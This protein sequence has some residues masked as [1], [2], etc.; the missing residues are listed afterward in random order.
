[1]GLKRALDGGCDSIEH[2]LDLDDAAIAQMVK[3]GTWYCPTMSPYY[4]DWEPEGTPA[5]IRDRKRAEVH[6]PSLQKAMKA[7]VKIA[8]G[9][10][11]GGFPWSD[12]M[13]QEFRRMVE[14][15]MTPAA[16]IRSATS[17]AAEMLGMEG[18]IGTIAPGAWAD[19]VAVTGDPLRDVRILEKID[20]VMKDGNVYRN[21]RR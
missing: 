7:G 17:S 3:Q 2:G 18:K 8:F 5:G 9:T 4:Y 6:G 1:V 10:D 11:A 19:I 15:G 16:A 14:F 13:A 12:P 20:F 21:D